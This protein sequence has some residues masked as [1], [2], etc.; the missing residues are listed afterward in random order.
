MVYS[1][2]LSSLGSAFFL[3]ASK[4]P[5]IPDDAFY[6]QF[7]VLIFCK[8]RFLSLSLSLSLAPPIFI[9]CLL[10]FG[11]LL[12]LVILFQYSRTSHMSLPFLV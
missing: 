8:T 2:P 9:L 4:Q 6:I 5:R 3:A 12:T 10:G 11:A 1:P 7:E